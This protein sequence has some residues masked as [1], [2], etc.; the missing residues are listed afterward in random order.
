MN[1]DS[2]FCKTDVVK[3]R[4]ENIKKEKKSDLCFSADLSD[5]SRLWKILEEIGNKIVCCKIHFDIVEDHYRETFRESVI[6]LSIKHNFLII[7]DRK[8][9]DISHIVK[10]QYKMF[11]VWVDLVTVHALVT[12]EVV[13]SL[14]GVLL[15]ANMSNNDY[16]FSQKAEKLALENRNNVIGFITQKRLHSD[17]VCMTPG[18]SLVNSKENDQRYRTISEVDT[19]FKIVGRALYN[20]N[21]IKEDLEKLLKE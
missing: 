21:N 11:E 7:E 2:L 5:Y 3:Y 4:L 16:D 12:N 19:D 17:F 8:F 13:Q 18:L 1:V 20:S 9:N 15:V 6:E 10:K 14:A